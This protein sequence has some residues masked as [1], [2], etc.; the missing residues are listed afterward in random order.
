M[1]RR[2]TDPPAE[3]PVTRAPPPEAP[4][5]PPTETY[6]PPESPWLRGLWML[7]FALLFG[8]A[9][10]ILGLAALVQFLWLVIRREKNPQIA[11]FG[12][13]L[14]RWLHDAARFLAGASDDKPFPFRPLG[15]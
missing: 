1:T 10:S 7:F 8:V 15:G 9:Q 6:F 12:E 2:P 3:A 4:S 11:A 14:A 5:G 13:G